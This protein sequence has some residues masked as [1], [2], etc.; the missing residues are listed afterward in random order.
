MNMQTV[1]R[2]GSCKRCG[3][4]CKY[5]VYPYKVPENEA[6]RNETIRWLSDH[7]RTRV[8]EIKADP[9]MVFVE[10]FSPCKYLKFSKSQK[11]KC[12]LYER[13]PSMCRNFPMA[14]AFNCSGFDFVLVSEE[15]KEQP[16]DD[17]GFVEVKKDGN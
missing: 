11:A 17:L 3:N 1:K 2:V 10:V 7:S 14:K 16:Y 13:R 9:T 6:Q 15:G 12:R 5:I 8:Y 4:C